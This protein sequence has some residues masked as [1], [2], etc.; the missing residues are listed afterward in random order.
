MAPTLLLFDLG[1]VLIENVMFER[2]NALLPAPRPATELKERC[3]NSDAFRRFE[4]GHCQPREF[5]G[6]F[7]AEW[8][9]SLAPD[10][11]LEEFAAWPKGFFPGAERLLATL[12]QRYRVACLSN[13]NAVH[14]TRFGGFAEHFDLAL[15]SHLL[16]VVKPDREAFIRSLDI[17][18]AMPDET[19]FFDDSRANVDTARSLGIAAH[20]VEGFD[21]LT[22]RLQDLALI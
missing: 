14:W 1:G 18:G 5:A 19:L 17:C 2:L 4:S 11:F 6:H 8:K 12:R 10:A 20:H 7:I 15:S 13:S 9:L 16:G 22:T 21:A 3:L